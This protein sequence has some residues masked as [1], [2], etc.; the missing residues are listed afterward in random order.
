[1][2]PVLHFL[3]PSAADHGLALDS[4]D[5]LHTVFTYNVFWKKKKVAG[6]VLQ[7]LRLTIKRIFNSFIAD[8]KLPIFAPLWLQDF[9][10]LRVPVPLAVCVWSTEDQTCSML[11]K[12][13]KWKFNS[14]QHDS[15][16]LQRK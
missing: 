10:D 13:I 1:M 8:I 12:T 9:E 5:L 3:L 14:W 2:L 11:N 6:L 16:L 4:T 7:C 15:P